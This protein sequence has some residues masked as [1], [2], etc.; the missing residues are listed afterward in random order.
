MESYATH[1]PKQHVNKHIVF[2]QL[3][4][5]CVVMILKSVETKTR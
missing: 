2:M 3:V 4:F 5:D 1:N